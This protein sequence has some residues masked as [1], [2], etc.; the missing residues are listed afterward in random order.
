MDFS[1]TPCLSFLDLSEN[2]LASIHGLKSCGELLELCLEENR[3]A[4]LGMALC[5]VCVFRKYEIAFLLFV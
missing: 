1:Q 2:R 3:V 4:R 5:I